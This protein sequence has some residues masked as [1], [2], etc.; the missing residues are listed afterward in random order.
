MGW[1]VDAC[2]GQRE[3]GRQGSMTACMCLSHGPGSFAHDI[4][5]V[6]RESRILI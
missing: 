2:L 4:D 5:K 6:D 1:W 3:K